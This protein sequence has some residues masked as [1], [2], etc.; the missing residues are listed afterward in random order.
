MVGIH[1]HLF[2]HNT[3]RPSAFLPSS[4]LSGAWQTPAGPV[5]HL[6]AM[7]WQT[8]L[9]LPAAC[10]P[11]LCFVPAFGKLLKAAASHTPSHCSTH[12]TAAHFSVLH[13]HACLLPSH[14]PHHYLPVYLRALL[15]A[16]LLHLCRKENFCLWPPYGCVP[17]VLLPGRSTYHPRP[18]P[19]VPA[20]S[21]EKAETLRQ[22]ESSSS[23]CLVY[24]LPYHLHCSMHALYTYYFHHDSRPTAS[25]GLPHFRACAS[26]L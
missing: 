16:E 26:L 2:S 18:L 25:L 12:V 3:T 4:P 6:P 9:A 21:L 7:P 17:D 11:S 20:F 15:D 19:A 13:Q 8:C 23:T 1:L 14:D 5:A 22:K 24:P 10:L